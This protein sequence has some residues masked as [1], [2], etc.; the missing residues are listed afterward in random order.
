MKSPKKR[1]PA[2]KPKRASNMSTVP[3]QL[4]I[5]LGDDALK[6]LKPAEFQWTDSGGPLGVIAQDIEVINWDNMTS[7]ITIPSG[8]YTTTSSI[9]WT[10]DYTISGYNG[11]NNA[12][13][14]LNDKGMEI[15]EGG[16]IKIGGKSLSEAI[17]KIE[18]RLGILHP[19]PDLED[20]WEQLKELRK[21]Y[22]EL[23]K[24]LLEKEKMW[25][26]LKEK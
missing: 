15:K 1:T 7:T 4:E 17:E 16:D 25:K 20:R 6:N 5:D 10:Q 8:N 26:I 12:N 13:V 22:Q 14:I 3:E 11:Y 9:N 24:E 23:E 2:K 21:Q 19:N 18:E